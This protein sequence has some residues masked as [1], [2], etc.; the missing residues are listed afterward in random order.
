MEIDDHV[1]RHDD[2]TGDERQCALRLRSIGIARVVPVHAL[3][4]DRIEVRRHLL[5]R[6][7]IDDRDDD[8]RAGERLRV[9]ARNEPLSVGYHRVT[10]DI[11]DQIARTTIEESF[12]N[13]TNSR[14][15]GGRRSMPSAWPHAFI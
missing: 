8:H 7:D 5:E 12:V 2:L 15:E 6:R 14:M 10:V 13:H 9:D 1:R 3:P 11:R 4:V